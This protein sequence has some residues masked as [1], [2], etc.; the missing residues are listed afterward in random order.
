M[1][2]SGYPKNNSFEKLKILT[3]E[4]YK[5]NILNKYLTKSN[6]I[7]LYNNIKTNANIYK[8]INLQ[9]NI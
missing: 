4:V 5:N 3:E 1:K 2:S 8:I 7:I 6:N 9:M